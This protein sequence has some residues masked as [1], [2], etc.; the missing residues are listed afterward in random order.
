MEADGESKVLP[1]R[2]RASSKLGGL[3]RHAQFEAALQ[4]TGLTV[5]A[6]ADGDFAVVLANTA[7]HVGSFILVEKAVAFL[8]AMRLNLRQPNGATDS[9]H[10]DTEGPTAE[11]PL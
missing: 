2:A 6:R 3:S 9:T 11:G 8:Q 5:I 1:G 7:P 10:A 4:A